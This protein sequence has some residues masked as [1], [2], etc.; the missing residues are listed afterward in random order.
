[1]RATVRESKEAIRHALALVDRLPASYR[2]VAKARALPATSTDRLPLF[3]AALE[4]DPSNVDALAFLAE[5]YAHSSRDN[6][7]ERAVAF[8]E[9]LFAL[10]YHSFA[11]SE[12]QA[13][14]YALTFG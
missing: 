3:A 8:R 4:R 7:P 5:W 13:Y 2:D 11:F 14:T 9:R 6:D 10:G 12:E 1:M